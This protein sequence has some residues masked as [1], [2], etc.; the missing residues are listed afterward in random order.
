MRPRSFGVRF[1]DY[2]GQGLKILHDNDARLGVA[3]FHHL[4]ATHGRP[5]LS[6]VFAQP[7]GYKPCHTPRYRE[8]LRHK[9]M[10]QLLRFSA[11]L[12][13][14]GAGFLFFSSLFHS[15]PTTHLFLAFSWKGSPFLL[16]S[17]LSLD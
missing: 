16:L 9:S 12:W 14:V 4:R 1:L 8:C 17:R 3:S 7:T 5:R 11:R 13:T 6:L 10:G 2:V 15:P